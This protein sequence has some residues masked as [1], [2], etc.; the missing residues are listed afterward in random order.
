MGKRFA[1]TTIS[2]FQLDLKAILYKNK[3]KKFNSDVEKLVQRYKNVVPS[4]YR[5]LTKSYLMMS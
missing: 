2:H 5:V 1:T 4:K 3:E